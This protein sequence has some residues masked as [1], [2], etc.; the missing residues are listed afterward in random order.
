MNQGTRMEFLGL[1]LK[2][3]GKYEELTYAKIVHKTRSFRKPRHID[4][5]AV[6]DMLREFKEL[7]Y[8]DQKLV[9]S[10]VFFTAKI[11]TD[12]NVILVPKKITVSDAVKEQTLKRAILYEKRKL[13]NKDSYIPV[14][15]SEA[16]P[17]EVRTAA[18][19]PDVEKI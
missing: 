11:Q 8:V 16:T 15:P 14:L 17:E 4:E 13:T 9:R 1:T 6:W 5:R 2:M 10:R 12:V 7:G 18:V 19:S 3:L